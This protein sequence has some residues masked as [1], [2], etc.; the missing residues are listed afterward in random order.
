MAVFLGEMGGD[1]RAALAHQLRCVEIASQMGDHMRERVFMSG[2]FEARAVLGELGSEN[3]S[4]EQ[5]LLDEKDML[6]RSQVAYIQ[7]L[8]GDLENALKGYLESLD[9]NRNY[10]NAQ[11]IGHINLTIAEIYFQLGEVHKAQEFLQESIEL[12]E[13]GNIFINACPRSMLAYVYAHQGNF[14]SARLLLDEARQTNKAQ[15][16]WKTNALIIR[17][18]EALVAACEGNFD[19]A[20]QIFQEII[21]EYERLEARLYRTQVLR[22]WGLLLSENNRPGDQIRARGKLEGA[23]AGYRAMGATL[24]AQWVEDKLREIGGMT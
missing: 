3:K 11:V 24:N 22:E 19:L 7:F 10:G 15:G 18:F 8:Y 21:D 20:G 16:D 6:F 4:L 2:V 12:S 9:R 23:L 13:Q 5:V 17:R 1:I 14:E